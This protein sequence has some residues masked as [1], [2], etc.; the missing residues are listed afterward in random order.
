MTLMVEDEPDIYSTVRHEAIRPVYPAVH[1]G[2]RPAASN[3]PDNPRWMESGACAGEK[4]ELLWESLERGT[5][6]VY[7]A[8]KE[9]CADCPV[10]EQC[11][12]FQMK[13]E[14]NPAGAPLSRQ[15]RFGV[16]GGLTPQERWDL[17]MEAAS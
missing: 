7:G 4:A 11:L 9:V 12:A 16:W 8:A 10:R 14:V 13:M 1:V 17:A 15:Q 6:A 3:L 2:G 5:A